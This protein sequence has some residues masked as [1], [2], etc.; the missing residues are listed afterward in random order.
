M[1]Q[2]NDAIGVLGAM[3]SERSVKD[4]QM[5]REFGSCGSNE[6]FCGKPGIGAGNM[7]EPR[8]ATD[9]R[10]LA[11]FNTCG[12]R[13]NYCGYAGGG[14]KNVASINDNPYLP[15]NARYVPLQ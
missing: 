1:N 14:D 10:M 3:A 7:L 2:N 4:Q 9:Q 8:S 11:Q 6:A 5:Q 15:S 13:E 12:S